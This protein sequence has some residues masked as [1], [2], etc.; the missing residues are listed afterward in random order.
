MPIHLIERQNHVAKTPGPA[1][2]FTTGDWYISKTTAEALLGDDL[3]LHGAQ[4]EPSHFGGKITQYRTVDSGRVVFTI[5]ASKLYK[6][7]RTSTAGWGNEKKI[8]L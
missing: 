1:N 8:I 5:L 2:E 6:G 7:R 3:F 4:G